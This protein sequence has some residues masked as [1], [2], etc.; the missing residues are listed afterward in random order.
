MTPEEERGFDRELTKILAGHPKEVR[1][2]YES[3]RS[4]ILLTVD[5]IRASGTSIKEALELVVA[6]R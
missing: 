5:K 4:E 2:L 1:D 3:R 6:H